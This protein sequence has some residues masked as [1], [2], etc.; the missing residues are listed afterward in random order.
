MVLLSDQGIKGKSIEPNNIFSFRLQVG[1]FVRVPLW[2]N[3]AWMARWILF[4]DARDKMYKTSKMQAAK[5]IYNRH[6]IRFL[7]YGNQRKLFYL[8]LI[9]INS[10]TWI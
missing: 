10:F 3:V 9:F 8:W 6:F 2:S 7:I 5:S 1:M 4:E